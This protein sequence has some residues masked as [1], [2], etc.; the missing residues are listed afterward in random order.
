[1]KVPSGKFLNKFSGVLM[2]LLALLS[3]PDVEI[4]FIHTFIGLIFF[5]LADAK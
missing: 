5:Q 1:M 4:M 2:L 3:F